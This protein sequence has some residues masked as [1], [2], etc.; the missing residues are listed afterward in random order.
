MS[1][2]HVVFLVLPG[3][4]LLDLA[5]P[6]DVFA[7]ANEFAKEVGREPS[8]RLSFVGPVMETDTATGVGLRITD[9]DVVR[10]PIDTL[11]VPGGIDFAQTQFDPRSTRWIRRRSQKLRRIV[12]ICSG[13]FVLADAG[14]LGG[15]RV[16]THWRDLEA[17]RRR[18]PDASVEGDPLYIKDGPIY[19]SAGITA[20]IDLAVA[21]VEE[22]LGPEIAL[23]VAR[24][25]VMFLRRP[26]GQSQFSAALRQPTAEH[27]GILS[28]FSDVVEN[29]GKD[30]RIPQMARHA[31][32]STRHFVRVFTRETGEPPAQYVQRIRIERAR[33]LLEHGGESIDAVA[34]L[35]GFGSAETMRRRFQQSL[36]VA[37]SEYRSRFAHRAIQPRRHATTRE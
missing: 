37:P 1:T 5:G 32:M 36:G 7:A 25:L 2:L 21:L 12:S 13:A 26:G 3:I 10:G 20:G 8:Y 6:A 9:L 28:V 15:R 27:P 11:V 30:H 35:C 17:L 4:Q 18:M 31:G 34:E 19:T 16:T 22:D 23:E 14:L 29:P 24:A 33:H